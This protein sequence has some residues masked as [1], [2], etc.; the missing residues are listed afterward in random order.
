MPM[1]E[2][3]IAI[4][5]FAGIVSFLS[6]C[7]LPLI[8]AFLSYLTGVSANEIQSGN[9]KAKT[10]IFLNALFFVLGF[11]VIFSLAGILLSS[12]LADIS[13]QLRTWFARIGG[14]IIILFG[15]YLLKLIRIPFL[16]REHKIQV[17][18]KFKYSYITSFIFG[19]T[20]AIGWTPCVGAILGAILTLAIVNPGSAFG[21]LLAYSLGLGIPFLLTGIFISQASVWI[22]K[23]EKGLQYFSYIAGVILIILGVFVF[24]NKLGLISNFAYA[25]RIF[26]G[27]Q[28]I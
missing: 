13:F 27:F 21:L 22:R 19:S 20:F 3:N 10:K 8:P 16:E 6:P 2:I 25:L 7:I 17:K 23:H 9:T 14:I 26:E 28:G 15:L 4:A 12:L 1:N 5:F 24:T 11:S 18:K